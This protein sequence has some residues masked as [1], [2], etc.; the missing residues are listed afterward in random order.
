MNNKLRI[1]RSILI[2]VF[3]Y[4]IALFITVAGCSVTP[5]DQEAL[6]LAQASYDS[7][8]YPKAIILL[9]QLLQSNA[10]N[11]QARKLL[12][13]CYL[14]ERD[15]VSAEKEISRVS[16][17]LPATGDVQ[18]ILMASWELQGKH[19]KIIETYEQGGF[20]EV[21]PKIAL[22]I[23]SFSYLFEKKVE[24]GIE[25]ANELLEIDRNSVIALRTLSYAASVKDDNA[26]AV[27]YLQQALQIDK[28][29]YKTWR[30]LGAMHAKLEDHYEAIELYE[31]A[32]AK[33]EQDDPEKDQ[34]QIKV[35]LIHLMFHLKRLDESVVYINDLESRYRNNPFVIYLSGL[36]SYLKQDYDTA[37]TKLTQ[38]HTV[39]PNHLPTMLLLGALQFAENNLE[40]A[41]VLLT[42]YVNQVPT[43]LV[44]RKL[45]GEIKLR[46]DRPN[47]ALALLESSYADSNDQQIMTMIGLAAS[48]SGE[49]SRGIDFLKK[50]AEANPG[51]THIR[52]ELAQLYISHG[53]VDEAITEL[54]ERWVG[55]S[56]K[57]DT[58]LI[59]SYIKKGDFISARKLSDQLL[60]RDGGRT[61][62]IHL[63]A[64]I[65]LNSG[66]RNSARR[67]FV[68]AVNKNSEFI[69]GQLALARMDFEDGRLI[70]GSDR[71]NL[72][73][74]TEPQNVN[75]MML[76]AQISERSGKQKEALFWLEKAVET[77]H[78]PWLPRV[79]LARYYLRRKEPE[80]AAIYLDDENLRE[81]RNPVIRSMLA[82]L[83]KQGGRI[84]EAE[85]TIRKLLQENPQNEA[86][87]LQ[88][89]DL[90]ASRGDLNAARETLQNLDREIPTSVK[91][92]LLGYK[93]EMGAGNHQQGE[94]IVKRLLE[95]DKTRLLGVVLQADYYEAMG[96]REKAIKGLKAHATSQ[97]PFGIVQ[98]L[99]DLY[100]KNNDYNSAIKLLSTWK[101]ANS[102]NQQVELALA[103]TYQSAGKL[104]AAQKL[105]GDL[106]EKNPRNIV[107]LNNSALLNFAQA[108]KKAL[109][110]A[111][112]AYDISGNSSVAVVDTY[113]WLTHRSGDTATALK[114]LDPILETA[115]DPSILYHYA[116]MLA[117]SG[118]EK[119]AEKVLLTIIEEGQQFP[120]SDQARQ[121][122]SEI[123]KIKG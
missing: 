114:L 116:V 92:K 88:L 39:L 19:K 107:A 5:S 59:L 51:D 47:E 104:D 30:D 61:E 63:R 8:D 40:Q 79:I 55:Q 45:L 70:A 74:A 34:F 112:Q 121:L 76:L 12:A 10:K 73:L 48:Q 37:I 91:G 21:D 18:S 6:A 52:E 93:L 53:A 26:E 106:L 22:G 46:L 100:I 113:A 24:K 62:D 117:K 50:A 87:Y 7:G 98:K 80:K 38:V 56:S 90:Q 69:P 1:P 77:G 49:Y 29:D 101:K 25:L 105:Y 115:S 14:E 123:S 118:K 15:G 72:V 13:K 66:N 103:I 99:S 43:H 85:A 102:E 89:A 20:N 36:Y 110:Q 31:T 4:V 96:D 44:A 58:L 35:N 94:R 120:E 28:E 16:N 42:R 11:F 33:I 122:L 65:E 27:E 41:N 60:E 9:K 54:E 86:A 17:A 119:D 71:L 68:D 23:V 81:S 32:L 75:A 82:M 109:E 83:N 95:E 57:R 84:D 2:I 111:K 97:A 3:S 67:Y 108:P 78:N 64:L